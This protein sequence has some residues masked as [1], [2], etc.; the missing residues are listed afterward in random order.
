MSLLLVIVPTHRPGEPKL[1]IVKSRTQVMHMRQFVLYS[2][3]DDVVN[4]TSLK[5]S[6]NTNKGYKGL[7]HPCVQTAG[8]YAPDF[9]HRCMLPSLHACA[10]LILCLREWRPCFDTR[11]RPHADIKHKHKQQVYTGVPAL[12]TLYVRPAAA[13]GA[14][15]NPSAGSC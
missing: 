11:H 1:K 12:K 15:H 13:A 7:T 5:T 14:A 4:Q 9:G 10:H 6:F 8:G 3:G 2:Y